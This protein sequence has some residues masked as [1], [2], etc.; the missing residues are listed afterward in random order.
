MQW[1]RKRSKRLMIWFGCLLMIGFLIPQFAG[2]G[3]QRQ[4]DQIIG[5]YINADGDRKKI[6]TLMLFSAARQLEILSNIGMDILSSPQFAVLANDPDLGG[7]NLIAELAPYQL[8]FSDGPTSQAV[9]AFLQQQILQ[10]GWAANETQALEIQN[11]VNQLTTIDRSEASRMF[12][13]LLNE[14]RQAGFQPSS[15]QINALLEVRREIIAGSQLPL[16]PVSAIT[17]RLNVT[18]NDIKQAIGNYIAIV[19]YGD[20]VT[21]AL[22][23]SEQELKRTIRWEIE[24]DNVA[25]NYVTFSANLFLDKIADPLELDWQKH[26]E[27]YNTFIAGQMDEDENPFGFGYKLSDRVQVEVLRVDL[28]KA[29]KLI[30]DEFSQKPL[31]QQEDQIQKYWA[32]H[33]DE[34]TETIPSDQADQAAQPEIR[35]QEFDQVATQ[36]REALIKSMARQKAQKLLSQAYQSLTKRSDQPLSDSDMEKVASEYT[37]LATRLSLPDLKIEYDRSDFLSIQSAQQFLSF[38]RTFT[39]PRGTPD[40][41]LMSLLFSAEPLRNQTDLVSPDVTPI[42]LY[43]TI[44]ALLT[45][46]YGNDT[47]AALLVRIIAVDKERQPESMT[48]DGSQG[49]FDPDNAET[50]NNLLLETIKSDF[51]TLQAYQLAKIQAQEFASAATADWSLAFE[52]TNRSLTELDPNDPNKPGPLRQTTLQANRD[53]LNQLRQYADQQSQNASYFLQAMI[54]QATVL[55]KATTLARQRRDG[56][57]VLGPAVLERPDEL[58]VLVFQDLEATPITQNQYVRRRAL[59]T[60]QMI[61]RKQ[62]VTVLTHY[63]PN[64]IDRRHQFRFENPED[65]SDDQETQP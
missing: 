26:F 40:Q 47:S 51:K 31:D 61:D 33:R 11:D 1:F 9:R 27:T 28:A 5:H 57:S 38:D 52:Q 2:N 39:V 13:L 3:G 54:R 16:P 59:A 44:D 58:S 36:A 14:A 34:F 17:K 4:R 65:Q 32:N 37:D 21:G 49:A 19:Q 6:S 22:T 62:A 7:V 64:N 30:E 29:R 43:E 15:E 63:N 53:S 60:A 42:K 20:M 24:M 50:E 25:G 41:N 8:F 10:G 23:L 46:S 18:E 48:D 35:Q 56:A 12:L 55:Q 45:Y